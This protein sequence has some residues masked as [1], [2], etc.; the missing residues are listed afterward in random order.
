M[1]KHEVKEAMEEENE[2]L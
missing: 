1:T 2:A